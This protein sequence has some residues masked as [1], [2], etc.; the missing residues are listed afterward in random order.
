MCHLCREFRL[1]LWNFLE[2]MSEVHYSSQ[3]YNLLS[4]NKILANF[5]G[6]GQ[7]GQPF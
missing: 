6:V 7:S 3:F 5:G 2:K 1:D 4:L